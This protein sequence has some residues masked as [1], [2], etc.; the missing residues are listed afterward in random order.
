MRRLFL[1]PLVVL[2]SFSAVADTNSSN[3]AE[4][5]AIVISASRIEQSMHEVGSSI[6]VL[7]ADELI[8]RGIS[9][10]GDAFREVP[11][12][13]VSSQ[14]PRGSLTQV[15]VRGNEA[16][17]V[18]VLVDGMRVSNAGTGEF[19]FSNMHL[20]G[21]ERIEVLLGPQSTLYGSDAAAGV[22]NVIT[23]KGEGAFGGQVHAATG[24]LNTRSGSVQVFGGDQ[25]WHYAVSANRYL[26][27]GISAAAEKNGNSEKDGHESNGVK[28]KT[29]YDADKFSTWLTYNQSSSDYDFDGSDFA[30]GM[31]VDETDNHQTTDTGAASWAISFPLLDGRL[32]NQLQ[33]SRSQYDYNSYSIFFGSGSNYRTE[34]DR[35]SIEYQGSYQI[36]DN[37]SLQFGIDK[38]DDALL[39]STFD[40][41]AS[42]RGT[43]LQWSGDF[44]ATNF[45]LG[46]RSDD[47]DEFNRHTT[48]RATASHQLDSNWRLRTAYGTGFKAPSLQELYDTNFSGNPNLKPEES[49]SLELGIEYR[50]DNY[51]TSATL[52]N[53]KTTNLIRSVGFWPNATMQNVDDADSR[54]LE[55]NTGISWQQTEL[56]A[57]LTWLDANET[58]ASVERERYRVP[59]LSAHVT[60]S[61]FYSK[62]RIWAEARYQGEKRDLNWAL[63]Q[64]VMLDAY[65]LFNLGASYEVSDDLSLSARI[66]NLFDEEYEEIYSYGTLG[67]TATVSLDVRF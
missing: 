67:R 18:L 50:H 2:P 17:H 62:G 55:L 32:S 53:Q 44:D 15:R 60:G 29:G 12:L 59:K 4:S 13:A 31:A 28:I 65:W 64:D 11:S 48:Y 5:S 56:S 14:G 25:G 20:D 34:T 43:Y 21:I 51:H 46:G 37:H 6:T 66:D 38:T 49:S 24:S 35:D 10:V 19:D 27:D 26:T 45:T 57:A 54:G 8:E 9:F 3:Q 30:T 33:L 39:V 1:A 22:I 40:R 47:H 52:F 36:D 41:E 16:N 23:R 63:Q 42:V 7:S 61:Y 58:V